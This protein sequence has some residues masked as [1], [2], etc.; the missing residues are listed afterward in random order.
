MYYFTHDSAFYFPNTI[1][2]KMTYP[3]PDLFVDPTSFLIA[4]EIQNYKNIELE[5]SNPDS[6]NFQKYST[7]YRQALNRVCP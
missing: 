6:P 4:I 7:F 2:W 3:P 1:S 5:N